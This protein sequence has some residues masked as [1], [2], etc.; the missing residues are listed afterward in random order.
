VTAGRKREKKKIYAIQNLFNKVW[1]AEEDAGPR[2]F[3]RRGGNGRKKTQEV[4][5]GRGGMLHHG[6][7]VVRKKG[8][9]T[10]AFVGW[11]R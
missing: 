1:C 2:T 6:K 8:K 10:R 5:T 3:P 4:G 11:G 9:V 7:L